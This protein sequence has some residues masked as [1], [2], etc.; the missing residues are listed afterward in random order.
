M[1]TDWQHLWIPDLPRRASWAF[2]VPS[3][4][5]SPLRNQGR[6]CAPEGGIHTARSTNLLS[7]PDRWYP[8]GGTCQG[9]KRVGGDSGSQVRVGRRLGGARSR[10]LDFALAVVGSRSP[11]VFGATTAAICPVTLVQGGT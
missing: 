10:R 2:S 4:T 7:Q 1:I 3:P 9:V 6:A 5:S 11:V 8:G